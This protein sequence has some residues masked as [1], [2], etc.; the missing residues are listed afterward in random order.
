MVELEF[1]T[2]SSFVRGSILDSG[3]DYWGIQTIDS[4][5]VEELVQAVHDSRR[6]DLTI[7]LL[8]DSSVL[9]AIQDDF[10]IGSKTSEL[11]ADSRLSLRTI[12]DTQRVVP[13]LVFD[14]QSAYNLIPAGDGELIQT[15]I[16]DEDMAGRL[17]SQYDRRWDNGVPKSVDQPPH[18]TLL[19]LAEPKLSEP[20]RQDLEQAFTAMECR[21]ADSRTDPV[22]VALVVAAKH[23]LL[24]TDFVEWAEASTLATQSK[25]SRHKQQLEEIGLIAA[26]NVPSGVGRP[27]QRLSLA[28]ESMRSLDA[29]ELVANVQTVLP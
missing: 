24:L 1:Q 17:R 21:A 29:D 11:Q 18:A 27:R 19:S 22:M 6:T 25:V 12:A 26:E 5:L 8:T 3:S 28:T 4:S 7:E 9:S 20:V 14:E 16:T 10:F 13:T 2:Y 15:S 23:E